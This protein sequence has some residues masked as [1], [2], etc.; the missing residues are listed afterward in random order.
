MRHVLATSYF[1]VHILLKVRECT[2]KAAKKRMLLKI[3]FQ[4]TDCGYRAG[5]VRMGVESDP[6]LVHWS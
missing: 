2:Y 4:A 5:S 6:V 1:L 3:P